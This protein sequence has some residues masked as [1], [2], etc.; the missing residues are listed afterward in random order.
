MEAP[1]GDR[2]PHV[3]AA[4][5]RHGRPRRTAR[6]RLRAATRVTADKRPRRPHPRRRGRVR[7]AKLRR[8]ARRRRSRSRPTP[9]ACGSSFFSYPSGGFAGT[10]DPNTNAI[11]VTPSVRLDWRVHR[12]APS[13]P[14][15]DAVGRLAGRPL[16]PA[17]DDVGR[18]GRLRAVRSSGRARS[19]STGSRSSCRRTPGRPTTSAT[20]TATAGA[21]AGTSAARR[22][23]STCARPY[24]DFGVPFRFRD[25]DSGFISWLQQTGKQVDFLSDDDLE[26]VASGDDAAQ[27]LRPRRLPRPRGVRHRARLRRG[28]ALP[29][30]RRQPDLPLGEQLLLEG[31]SA[32]APTC[33]GSASGAGSAGPRRSSIGIQYVASNYG[34]SEARVR[35]GRRGHGAVGVRGD[36]ACER[37][38]RSGATGSRSTRGLR[39]RRRP[40]SSSLARRAARDRRPRRGDDVLPDERRSAR[41]SRR[42]RSTSRPRSA[43][44]AVARLGR[45]TSGLASERR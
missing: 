39:A 11:P 44:P 23:R 32:R 30:P 25:W 3:P 37:R 26:R 40:V 13:R 10:R 16:L 33:A 38:R 9:R 1:Q 4:L 6:L 14:P 22:P 12:N 18:P 24:L 41:S 45:T 34:E 2:E 20:R 36:R 31:A 7:E 19:A 28:R 21:T 35:R 17:R 42:A 43:D 29:G 5:H 15:G 8:R 27:R